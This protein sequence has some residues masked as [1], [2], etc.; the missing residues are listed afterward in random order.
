MPESSI[1]TAAGGAASP[2]ASPAAGNVALAI[3][4]GFSASLLAIGLARFAYT[5]LIPPLIQAHWFTAAQAVTLGAANFAGYLAGALLGRPLARAA[6]NRAALRAM[7]L[8][9]TAAFF[10]CAYPLSVSWFFLWRFASGLAGGAIMVL[11]ASAVLPHIPATRRG[12]AGGMIFVGLGVGIAASGTLIPR[13]L[14]QG[15]QQTWLGLGVLALLLTAVSWF[16]WPADPP[17]AAAA[18]SPH[19]TAH[20]TP[21]HAAPAPRKALALLYA[22]YAANALGLVPVMMLLVDYVARGLGRG[23]ATGAACWV[24]YGAAAIAGPLACGYIADRIGFAKAYRIALALQVI[25][26]ALLVLSSNAIAIGLATVILGALTPGVVTLVLGR[27]NALLPHDPAAQRAAWSRAT[28][29]FALCQAA[30]GYGYAWLF[31]RSHGHY[32]LIF[33]CGTVALVLAWVADVVGGSAA[34]EGR[35]AA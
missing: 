33:A 13:L 30:G 5:P 9:A 25:G 32:T 16:G 27:V 3:L 14:Q 11:A 7:M 12:F 1:A 2:A 20:T 17:P 29:A 21:P 28:T 19:T 4:A 10:A 31:A 8:L 26:T 15:L 18:A 22:Q 24:L 34:G 35:V 6:G 23:A